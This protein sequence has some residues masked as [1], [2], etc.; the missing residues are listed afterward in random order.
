MKNDGDMASKNIRTEAFPW[1]VYDDEAV[2]ADA[3]AGSSAKPG[4]HSAMRGFWLFFVLLRISPS[5]ALAHKMQFGPLSCHEQSQLPPDFQVVLDAYSVFGDV[6]RT[7]FADWWRSRGGKHFGKKPTPGVR[8]VA[9]IQ[10]AKGAYESAVSALD[11]HFKNDRPRDGYPNSVLLSI[12]LSL[13][14]AS[15]LR[16]VE[17]V[18]RGFGDIAAPERPQVALARS[19]TSATVG[20]VLEDVKLMLTRAEHPHVPLWELGKLATPHKIPSHA[21]L[22]EGRRTSSAAQR[23]SRR[24]IAQITFR[25][26][27][28]A[29]NLAENA[30]RG[31]YP[32]SD[33]VD[34]P[35]FNCAE[36]ASR[37]AKAAQWEADERKRPRVLRDGVIV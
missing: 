8:Q 25:D 28:R 6:Q 36:I 22:G 27:G 30:A 18:L 31:K 26:L 13:S 11:W 4:A 21:D 14:R 32:S 15:A 16:Q 17:L 37:L 10:E 5:Y 20:F 29:E 33:R 3:W 2:L 12:P 9:F 23:D 19:L 34:K 35:A 7:F 1:V 24:R